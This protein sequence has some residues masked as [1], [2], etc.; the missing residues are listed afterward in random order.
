MAANTPT[1]DGTGGQSAMDE[2]ILK[3]ATS[4]IF[5]DIEVLATTSPSILLGVTPQGNNCLHIST[6]HGHEEFCLYALALERSLLE[7]V[8][9]ENETPLVIAVSLGHA[10]LA[11][12]LLQ[13]CCG[14]P[15][16]SRAILQ[17]DRYGFNALHHAIRNGHKQLA[18]DLIAEEPA[19]SGA[20]TRYNESLIAVMWNFVDVLENLLDIVDS[21]HMGQY[22]CHALHAAARNGNK[23]IA[24]QIMKK[25]PR[26]ATEADWDG[27][28]PLRMA[29]SYNKVDVLQVL[30]EQRSSLA[31]ETD[32]DGYPLLYSAATR[33]QVDV[34]RALLKFCPDAFYCRL[35]IEKSPIIGESSLSG[36]TLTCLQIA[37]KNGH[38][39]FVKFILQTRQL[40]KLINMQDKV[41]RTALHYAV[42]QCDPRLVAAL[43]SHGSIDPT[44][45]D[46]RGN[47]A[48]SQLSSITIVDKTLDW[49]EVHVLMSKADPNDDDISL[50]NLRKGAK[51]QENIKSRRQRESMTQKY[52]SNTSLVAILL[53]TI[54]FTAAFTLPGGYSSD[55]GNAGLP[56]MS[57]KVTFIVFLIFDTLAMCSAFV[58]AFICLMGKWE[59]DKFTTCYIFVTK[60]LTWF[61]YL[62]TV[63]AFSTG[64]YTV[65]APRIHWLAILICSLVAFFFILTIF[66]AKWPSLKLSFRL[67]QTWHDLELKFLQWFDLQFQFQ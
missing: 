21:S 51:K 30:L 52:R 12:K 35:V 10:S 50:Y 48:A 20:V 65:L 39:E 34:A 13:Q 15:R 58:V 11:S 56:T 62:A 23:D 14:R 24:L 7:N 26:L 54:T 33:G 25:R 9:C 32:K 42:E 63:T 40:R 66:I 28:T 22:G 47:S 43:L 61:A 55:S 45:L 1:T 41:G 3:A 64:L 49:K 29:I 36:D 4:G 2:R 53:A 59:D 57:G 67:G 31:Y 17:Q 60:K 46:N 37:V 27:I 44:I 8:N 16:L 5:W 19:L 6:I 18:L 38:L